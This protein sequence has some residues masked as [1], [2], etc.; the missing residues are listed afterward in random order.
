MAIAEWRSLECPRLAR[1]V[2]ASDERAPPASLRDGSLR[3]DL[4]QIAFLPRYPNNEKL[5]VASA[6]IYE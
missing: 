6:V 2:S 1:R 3:S 5:Q 4:L